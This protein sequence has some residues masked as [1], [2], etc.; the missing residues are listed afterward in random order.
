M[1]L[2]PGFAAFTAFAAFMDFA[3]VLQN[4]VAHKNTDGSHEKPSHL[5]PLTLPFQFHSQPIEMDSLPILKLFA[6]ERHVSDGTVAS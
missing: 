3:L 1:V 4:R 5:P 2:I 6:A